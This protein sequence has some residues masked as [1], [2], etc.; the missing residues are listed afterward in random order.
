MT[1]GIWP[2][3]VEEHFTSL[4]GRAPIRVSNSSRAAENGGPGIQPDLRFW[5]PPSSPLDQPPNV[6]LV[7]GSRF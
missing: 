7:G 6:P 1:A 4:N 3:G 2:R 5:R